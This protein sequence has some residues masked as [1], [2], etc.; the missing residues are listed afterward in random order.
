MRQTPFVSGETAATQADSLLDTFN[1]VREEVYGSLAAMLGNHA[2]AQD[3][4]QVAFLHCWRAREKLADVQ[5]LRAWIYRICLNAGRDV[6]DTAWRRRS[7]PLCT[8]KSEA[9]CR[10][11]TASAVMIDREEREQLQ[12]ALHRLRPDEKEIFLLR[13][14]GEL[15]FAEIAQ[16]RGRPV[17]TGKS[18]MRSAVRKLQQVICKGAALQAHGRPER[19]RRA[20]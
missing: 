5:N 9:F 18:L 16:R 7:R 12:A 17:A 10:Q 2:D 8:V 4:L 20:I 1:T 6:R 14:D 3:A 13:Q 19:R 11:E 15:T